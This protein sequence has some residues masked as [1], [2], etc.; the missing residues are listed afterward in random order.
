[1][2]DTHSDPFLDDVLDDVLDGMSDVDAMSGLD[3]MSGEETP[4]PDDFEWHTYG[5][6]RVVASPA[7]RPAAMSPA[8]DTETVRLEQR[9]MPLGAISVMS[10]EIL[11]GVGGGPLPTKALV[12]LDGQHCRVSHR[13]WKSIFRRYR[14]GASTFRYFHPQE[15]FRRVCEVSK[16]DTLRVM[17]EVRRNGPPVALGVSRPDHPLVTV[18]EI[19]ELA[20][21]HGATE[22]RYNDGSVTCTFTPR[23]GEK[24]LSIGDDEFANRFT[25]D[26]PIDGF[27]NAQI[28]LA[29]MRLLCSNGLVGYHRA[30][31]SEVPASRNP[32]H[33]LRRAVECFDHS[34]G[35]AAIRER[36]L[37]AQTSWA[38]VR[39]ANAV[40]RQ[41]T[42]MRVIEARRKSE[43]LVDLDQLTGRIQEFYGLTN[44]D[45]L[46]VR[47]QRLLPVKC[48]VYDLLNFAGEVATH[49]AHPEDARPLQAWIGSTLSEEFDLEGTAGAAPEFADLF[50]RQPRG[51]A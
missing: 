20:T 34:D 5:E 38:S 19:R 40:Y 6:P 51:E 28:Y 49:V 43:T 10:E 48:R 44:I 29:L 35:F 41:I 1:M 25:L 47:R 37:S 18:D 16:K 45:T 12:D 9:L 30:F 33:T 14:F 22:A 31:C 17:V 27:G 21:S 11:P 42:K 2:D 50:L 36:F 13:F 7:A 26:V 3:I 23:S 8:T 24:T 4:V 39:E 15:V 32:R 46:P